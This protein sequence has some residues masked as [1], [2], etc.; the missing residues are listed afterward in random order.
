MDCK[1]QDC[2][3]PV[4]ARGVCRF[5]YTRQV[6]AEAKPCVIEGCQEPGVRQG[7][8]CEKHYR[9][10]MRVVAP[11]CTVPGC[12]TGVKAHGLCEKHYQRKIKHGGPDNT[13]PRDWGSREAHPLYQSYMTHRRAV[14]ASMCQEWKDDFWAFVET[15]GDRPS[16]DHTLRRED[17]KKPLGPGNWFWK[18]KTPSADKAAYARNWR[19]NNKRAARSS[20]LKKTFG[21]SVEDYEMMEAKQGGLCAL[22]MKPPSGRF[23][24]LSVDHCHDNGR[25]RGLLCSNCNLALGLLKDDPELLRRAIAYVTIP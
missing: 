7:C 18:E 17:T 12:S 14:P 16:P 13:R 19:A 8:I 2:G 9:D 15:V 1:E 10:R 11:K 4:F 20:A 23:Q 21:I 3:R 22:C 24:N 5:H 25:V 6:R